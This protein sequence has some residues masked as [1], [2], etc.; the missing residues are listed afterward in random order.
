MYTCRLHKSEI[1]FFNPV[2]TL[3]ILLQICN[4][5]NRN[6]TIQSQ[7]VSLQFGIIFSFRKWLAK[8]KN[9]NNRSVQLTFC[10]QPQY[11]A[12][13]HLNRYYFMKYNC[14]SG[15]RITSSCRP[16]NLLLKQIL[17]VVSVLQAEAV[18]QP[19]TRIPLQPNH[20]ETPT[21]IEPR[22]VRPM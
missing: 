11:Q 9:L 4:S 8:T 17:R 19:A 5:I 16:E 15:N 1:C 21:H 20:T 10:Y 7:S 14:S 6:A 18:L 2:V 3:I 22:T 13:R 12:T